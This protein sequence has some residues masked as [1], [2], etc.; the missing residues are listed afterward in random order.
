MNQST[1]KVRLMQADDF[2]AVTQLMRKCSGV[3]R[4]EYYQLEFEELV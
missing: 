1:I 3:S 4:P 2:V